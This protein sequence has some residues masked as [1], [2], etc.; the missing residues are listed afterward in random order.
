MIQ[1]TIT[2][3]EPDRLDQQVNTFCKG[4]DIKFQS[5]SAIALSKL[6]PFQVEYMTVILYEPTMGLKE[7]GALWK[8]TQTVSVRLEDK[9]ITIDK[10]NFERSI[11]KFDDYFIADVDGKDYKFIANESSNPK[12]PNYKI[13]E[14]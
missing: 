13:Y 11:K 2:A 7:V 5:T 3:T 6:E 10:E 9:N 1:K 14:I 8:K 4:K 12:A